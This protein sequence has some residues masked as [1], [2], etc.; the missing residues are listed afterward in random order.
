MTSVDRSELTR[1]LTFLNDKGGV[2]KTSSVAN[3]GG[4]LAASGYRVLLIDLDPQANL[5]RD[6][7][8]REQSDEGDNLFL[9]LRRDSSTPLTPL[10]GVRPNLD[11]IPGGRHLD[12]LTALLDSEVSGPSGRDHR[13]VLAAA[14]IPLA[15][16]YDFILIDTPPKL[17]TLQKLALG[18]AHWLVIPTK[19]DDGSL[20]GLEYV[21]TLFQSAVTINPALDLLGV[22]I[23]GVSISATSIRRKARISLARDLGGGDLL[24]Q[25]ILRTSDTCAYECRHRGL[26]VHEL[27]TQNR[28]FAQSAAGLAQD[29]QA[30]TTEIVSR[31]AD[32][33]AA[34]ATKGGVTNGQR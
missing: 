28:K 30:L 24:L 15:G 2:F 4:L 13:D 32:A 20:D 11:V 16:E 29:Y 12:E 33:E 1:V 31:I 6:L 22:F 19:P 21:T 7:G 25:T 10:T 17:P 27:E 26:L 23:A 18:A 8:Y 34:A 5:Q 14:L 9:A 3:V